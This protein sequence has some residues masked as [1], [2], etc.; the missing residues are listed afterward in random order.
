MSSFA[1]GMLILMGFRVCYA[2]YPSGHL[3]VNWDETYL[4]TIP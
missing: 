1:V 2:R 3:A 4:S